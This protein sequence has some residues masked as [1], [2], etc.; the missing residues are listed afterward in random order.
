LIAFHLLKIAVRNDR[1]KK[2]V[3]DNLKEQQ[4]QNEALANDESKFI[5]SINS[6]VTLAVASSS[7]P[8]NSISTN[9]TNSATN[10]QE[11]D[12]SLSGEVAKFSAETDNDKESD[13][14]TN[15]PESIQATNMSY[16]TSDKA[17][18][19][20]QSI[21]HASNSP[22]QSFCRKKLTEDDLE[23]IDICKTLLEQTYNDSGTENTLCNNCNKE[24]SFSVN[25]PIVSGNEQ[26]SLFLYDENEFTQAGIRNCIKYCMNLPGN[27]D[28]CTDDRAK[29][30]KY[31]VYEI[32]VKHKFTITCIY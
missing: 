1:N 17:A 11:V 24:N 7:P 8:H 20:P 19:S 25:V 18:I 30:L 15:E 28:L 16:T 23:I 12:I 14:E 22:F 2:R 31:G 26:D 27:S 21:N 5:E 10:T 4:S 3:Q 9:E 32:T 29:L 6:V 13:H